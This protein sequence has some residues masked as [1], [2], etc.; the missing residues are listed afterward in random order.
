MKISSAKAKGRN[1]SNLLKSKLLEHLGSLEPED[2]VVTSGGVTGED[3]QLS[4]RAK[5]QFPFALECKARKSFS[6]YPHYE[7]AIRHLVN[8]KGY[9]KW[10]MLVIRGDRKQALVILSLDD[11]LEYT[12]NVNGTE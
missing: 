2:I 3:L 1:L 6:V 12:G 10:P 4:P 5:D 7:Q 9:Y 8:K 11:F